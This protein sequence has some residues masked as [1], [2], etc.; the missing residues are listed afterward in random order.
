MVLA[1]FDG[2]G[3]IFTNYVPF[4]TKVNVQYIVDILGNFWQVFKRKRQKTEKRLVLH[5]DNA[6]VH[7]VNLTTKSLAAKDIKMIPHPP[8]PRI[9]PR[10]NFSSARRCSDSTEF[11]SF[12][13]ALKCQ[14]SRC[15]GFLIPQNSLEL[16]SSWE[17]QSC[18]AVLQ[19]SVTL[20]LDMKLVAEAQ[21]LEMA[22][23]GG[24]KCYQRFLAAYAPY[25]HPNHA[26]LCYL[27]QKLCESLICLEL[28]EALIAIGSVVEAKQYISRSQDIFRHEDPATFFPSPETRASPRDTILPKCTLFYAA[29]TVLGLE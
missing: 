3:M 8:T 9:W 2:E 10:P 6:P 4:G 22:S 14:S 24:I 27:K 7:T 21:K 13:S 20:P 18:Q 17:C 16:E 28:G 12:A 5:W 23:S 25:L 1:F 19:S 26:F 11:G 29:S 15:D